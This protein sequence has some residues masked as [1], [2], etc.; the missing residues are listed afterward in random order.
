M[1]VYAESARNTVQT[2]FEDCFDVVYGRWVE[3]LALKADM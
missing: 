1:Y 3:L 2:N